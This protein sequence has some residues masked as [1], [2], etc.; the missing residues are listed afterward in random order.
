MAYQIEKREVWFGFAANKPGALAAKLQGL[1]ES[2]T[3]LDFLFAR[4][5]SKG[6][7]VFFT[8]PICGAAQARAA[9]QAGMSKSDHYA[10]LSVTGPDR[11]GLSARLCQLLGDAGINIEGLSGMAAGKMCHFY[12]AVAKKDAAKTQQILKKGLA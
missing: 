11:A 2:K 10:N 7:A 12:V 1:L 9:R 8:G 4:P 5:A 3:Q 6:Q